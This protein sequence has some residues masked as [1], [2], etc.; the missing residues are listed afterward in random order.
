MLSQDAILN[1]VLWRIAE[2][3]RSQA[4]IGFNAF[5][6]YIITQKSIWDRVPTTVLNP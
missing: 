3:S 1:V 2:K 5:A 4:W 6:L